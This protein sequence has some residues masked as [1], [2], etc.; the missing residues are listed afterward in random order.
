M[1]H[2]KKLVQN[3][4]VSMFKGDDEVGVK[5]GFCHDLVNNSGQRSENGKWDESEMKEM[6]SPT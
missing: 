5:S 3:A 6:K 2:K 4:P 1:I